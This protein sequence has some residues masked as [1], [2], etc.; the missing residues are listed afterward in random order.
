MTTN[1]RA[2]PLRRPAAALRRLLR[3]RRRG[4]RRL[5]RCAHAAVASAVRAVRLARP[6]ARAP[7]CRVRRPAA[8]VRDRP[9]GGRL[10]AAGT[11]VRRVVEGTRA[12]RPRRHGG[13]PRRRSGAETGRRRTHLRAGRRRPRARARSLAAASTCSEL[14]ARWGLPVVPSW[15]EPVESHASVASP[16]RSDAAT[17]AAPSPSRATCLVAR[18]ASSTTC[19][20]RARP[21]TPA[22]RRCAGR[23]PA[24]S[25]GVP[26]AGG[27]LDWSSSLV[28]GERDATSAHG[29]AR[30]GPGLG[31][32]VRRGEAPKARTPGSRGDAVEVVLDRERNPKI[33]D[34]HIVEATFY[35]K[36]AE[37]ARP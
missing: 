7:L 31:A 20:R 4:V 10:R 2:N 34:D 24:G 33:A 5:P 32:P 3:R 15:N 14:G 13:R 35:M 19:T 21:R 23:A 1:D 12:P 11:C 30:S 17:S 26:R 27:S 22:L 9:R 25:R 37:P 29:A 16:S 18:S 36:G 28:E 6:V 8:R